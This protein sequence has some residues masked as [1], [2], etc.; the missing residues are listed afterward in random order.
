M[1][2]IRREESVGIPWCGDGRGSHDVSEA[3]LR[4]RDDGYGRD[5]RGNLSKPRTVGSDTVFIIRRQ[6]EDVQSRPHRSPPKPVTWRS[7]SLV[8]VFQGG[9]HNFGKQQ[10]VAASTSSSPPSLVFPP[11]APVL[12]TDS[13][14]SPMPEGATELLRSALGVSKPIRLAVSSD[15]QPKPEY[16]DVESPYAI[17]GRGAGCDVTLNERTVSFR[18]A[19]LQA[20]G[21]RVL[22]VD[23]LSQRGVNWDGPEHNGWL[24]PAHRLEIADYRIQLF[25]DGWSGEESPWPSPLDSKTRGQETEV[26]GRLPDVHLQLTNR[27][28]KGMNWPINRILTLLGRDNGCRI[29]CGDDRISRVHCS[30]LLTPSGLWVID[31]LGR[32]GITV[33]DEKQSVALLGDGDELGVGH[34]RMCAVYESPPVPLAAKQAAPADTSEFA[35]TQSDSSSDDGALND[36]PTPEFLTQ[37]NRIFPVAF[38]NETVIVRSIGGIRTAPYQQMQLES[39]TITQLLM[40]RPQFRNVIVD[41]GATDAMD[42]IIISCISAMCRAAKN[43]AALCHCSPAMLAVLNDMNLTKVW[44]NFE[45]SEEAV[46]YVREKTD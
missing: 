13:L 45:T 32:G 27:K 8:D 18:H 34:Y 3:A 21:N 10:L 1:G 19:Y 29:T 24:T 22:C 6:T 17:I 16:V 20:F 2:E 40:T 11:A 44:P 33:N 14:D 42:S 15:R 43:R 5:E 30:L 23:L 46:A 31:L 36:L 25:D 37:N 7:C 12:S 9:R 39:N 28:L 41:V 26:F 38:E 4:G 35:V